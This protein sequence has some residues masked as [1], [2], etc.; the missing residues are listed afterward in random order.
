MG[1][2]EQ[3]CETRIEMLQDY[4]FKVS[5]SREGLEPL[6]MDEPQPVGKGQYPNAGLLVAAHHLCASVSV[7]RGSRSKE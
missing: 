2:E 7:G 5:F 4:Q 6:L 3:T 1:I